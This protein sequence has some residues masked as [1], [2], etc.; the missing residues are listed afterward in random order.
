MKRLTVLTLLVFSV[1]FLA[2]AQKKEKV[3]GSKIVTHTINEVENFENIEIDDNL[4]VY[5]VKGDKASV[6]IEAD[7][8]LHDAINFSVANNTLRVSSLKNVISA[9]KFSIRINYTNDLKLVVAKGETVINALNELQ[10][11]NVTVKNYGRSRSYL[12]VNSTYFTLILNDKAEAELNVKAQSTTLEL[13]NNAELKALIASPEFKLDMYENSEA[14][15]EGD[16]AQA[17][18][19]LD[20]SASL[21]SDNLTLKELE[22]TAE[23]HVKTRVNVIDKIA[24]SASGKAEIELYGQPKIDMVLFTN[25]AILYKKEK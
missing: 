8:N 21:T 4:E 13:S 5:L 20:N 16:A 12:N 15:I 1:T 22:L 3:K 23:G 11:E 14:E 25:N 24:I 10:G 9:K 17:K 2:Q 19:R 18:I 7:D 6:E